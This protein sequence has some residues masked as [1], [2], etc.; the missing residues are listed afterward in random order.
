MLL[1]APLRGPNAPKMPPFRD[2]ATLL[3]M[4]SHGV[5]GLSGHL[6]KHDDLVYR[7]GELSIN[8]GVPAIGLAESRSPKPD[9]L[10]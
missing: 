10:R 9:G 1:L 4:R 6:S 8:H 3:R 7:R 5:H 2:V